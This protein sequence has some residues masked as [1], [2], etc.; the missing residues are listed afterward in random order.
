MLL[1]QWHLPHAQPVA[2]LFPSCCAGCGEGWSVACETVT[3]LEL[4]AARR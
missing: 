3:H 2:L 1:G 4:L